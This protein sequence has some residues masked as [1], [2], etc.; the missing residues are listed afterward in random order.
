MVVIWTSFPQRLEARAMPRRGSAAPNEG[1]LEAGRVVPQVEFR[2]R[3]ALRLRLARRDQ[4]DTLGRAPPG[5]QDVRGPRLRRI[6]FV[7]SARAAGFHALA[8]ERHRSHRWAE[9]KPTPLSLEFAYAQGSRAGHRPSTR[10]R[11]TRCIVADAGLPEPPRPITVARQQGA[12]NTTQ[13]KP[14]KT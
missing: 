3:H 12:P 14:R 4:A 9:Q 13:T 11:S 6:G 2:C 1:R 8:P 7:D 5:A 10:A